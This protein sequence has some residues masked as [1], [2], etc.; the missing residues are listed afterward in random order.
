MNTYQREDLN[1]PS[2][3]A[4][5]IVDQFHTSEAD[6]ITGNGGA[7]VLYGGAGN[8]VVGWTAATSP[9]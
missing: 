3:A 4:I 7:D 8:D 1:Q 6:T 9:R 5:A 2:V